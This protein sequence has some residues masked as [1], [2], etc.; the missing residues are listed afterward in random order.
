MIAAIMKV[1]EMYPHMNRFIM[2]GHYYQR[3]ELSC[4]F[5]VK[6]KLTVED[7]ERNVIIRC[8]PGDSLP[9]ISRKI[10]EAVEIG[11][12][13]AEDEQ[14]RAMKIL[15]SLPT[16]IVN[17]V[18]G[19][20]KWLDKL[21][22]LP[23]AMTDLD[24][25]HVS[26]FMANLGSIGLNN[27]PTHHLFEWGNCSLFITS[28]RIKK[29]HVVNRMGETSIEDVL[30]VCFSIDERISE[31]FYYSQVIKSFRKFIENPHFLE[32]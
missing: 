25:L 26:V 29:D 17:I 19:A 6:T 8:L 23:L 12:N 31:G 24:A 28:G 7:P 13:I 18:T 10:K 2:G 14:D 22:L 9:I 5:V 4:A 16:G 3:N 32:N 15:F 21:G 30:N 11:K 1:M 20:V 27:A